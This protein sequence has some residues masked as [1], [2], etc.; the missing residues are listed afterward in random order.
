MAL[1][2]GVRTKITIFRKNGACVA[3]VLMNQDV[4]S[5]DSK[6]HCHNEVNNK[7]IEFKKRYNVKIIFRE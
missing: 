5:A 1:N 3:I 7:N 6:F 2:E 4:W